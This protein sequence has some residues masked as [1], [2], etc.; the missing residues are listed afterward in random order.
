MAQCAPAALLLVP[1]GCAAPSEPAAGPATATGFADGGVTVTV[2]LDRAGDGRR[3]VR[4]TFTPQQAGFHLYSVNLP[5]GGID[6]L[7]LPT[8]LA[9]RGGL[10]ADGT[11]QADRPLRTV[12][13]S[14]LGVDL[15]VYPDGAVTVTL[16]V[17]QAGPGQ[18]EAVVS[19]GACSEQ[20]CLMP[21]T[22]RTI[23]LGPLN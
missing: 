19:Y 21:V 9:V 23:P 16:P 7:G 20:R 10:T 6:G 15:P 4:A 18:A 12:S 8:R 22:D 13:P 3:L 1:T 5:A 17:R 11:P 14:G 2:R